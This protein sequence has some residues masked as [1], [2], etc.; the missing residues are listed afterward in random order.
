DLT[1][2]YTVHASG[3]RREAAALDRRRFAQV[4]AALRERHGWTSARKRP[5]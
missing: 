2:V 1:N 3:M 5:S 4:E